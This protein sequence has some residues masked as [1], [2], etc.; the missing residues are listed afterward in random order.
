VLVLTSHYT[1]D[2]GLSSFPSRADGYVYLTPDQVTPLLQALP[3]EHG[4]VTGPLERL[5]DGKTVI[6][7]PSLAGRSGAAPS[8]F[9]RDFGL[10]NG[11]CSSRDGQ[12]AIRGTVLWSF[13]VLIAG[14][15]PRAENELTGL[16]KA[17][18]SGRYLRAE[19]GVTHPASADHAGVV[20]VL[21]ST[22]SFSG[23]NDQVAVSLLPANAVRQV[24]SGNQQR[25]AKDLAA[26]RGTVVQKA[27]I[28]GAQAWS[29]LLAQLSA[30]F[31]GPLVRFA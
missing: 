21:G 8:P 23:D 3:F 4:N 22:A 17:V 10:E 26:D 27:M 9:G 1:A 2:H 14:I 28:T 5:P 11:Q 24:R 12:D 29:D 20:P 16:G 15:D 13:P 30:P 18:S 7:C 6:I 31:Q 25:I 19:E